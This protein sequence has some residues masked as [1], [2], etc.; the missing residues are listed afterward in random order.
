MTIAIFWV[1]FAVAV[2]VFASNR[3]RSGF[4][5]FIFSMVLS[6]LLGLIFCAVSQDLS[7]KEA[8]SGPSAATHTKCPACAEFVLPEATVCKHCGKDLVPD[9]SF[10]SRQLDKV[11]QAKADDARNLFFGIAFIVG[12]FVV[13]AGISKCNG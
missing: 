2:G 12:L 1:L 6:P 11:S 5:W 7:A 4:G 9:V 10:A 8:Q 13:A 3:G